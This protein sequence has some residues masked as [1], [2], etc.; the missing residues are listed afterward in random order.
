MK[1]WNFISSAL[2]FVA[3]ITVA[4]A[5]VFWIYGGDAPEELLKK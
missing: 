4:P 1:K 3:G 5:S 2:A